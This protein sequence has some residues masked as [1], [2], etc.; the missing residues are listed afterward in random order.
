M[1]RDAVMDLLVLPEQGPS[2]TKLDGLAR[3][4]ISTCF[5]DLEGVS[6]DNDEKGSSYR[7]E[8][9]KRCDN[10]YKS[11]LDSFAVEKTEGQGRE[12]RGREGRSDRMWQLDE[13]SPTER[14]LGRIGGG[15]DAGC[16]YWLFHE[17]LVPHAFRQGRNGPSNSLQLDA[18]DGWE[19]ARRER[20]EDF[21]W[22]SRINVKNSEECPLCILESSLILSGAIGDYKNRLRLVA[23]LFPQNS[24]FFFFFF[25]GEVEILGIVS[26][27]YKHTLSFIHHSVE[28]PTKLRGR[29][30][31][32]TFETSNKGS[33]VQEKGIET[34]SR[35]GIPEYANVQ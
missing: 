17:G 14:V 25:G 13:F 22:L 12:G 34:T 9:I 28:R 27:G 10:G 4:E 20:G 5:P 7:L 21:G 19:R 30:E 23:S 35:Y 16:A 26:R 24:F 18:E 1:R 31:R 2:L 33:R 32:D 8:L 15:L 29:R 6:S 11:H 3:V